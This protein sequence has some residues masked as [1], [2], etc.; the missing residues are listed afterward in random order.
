MT[1]RVVLVVDDE[2]DIRQIAT[3]ALGQVGGFEVRT[4]TSGAEAIDACLTSPPD[5]VLMDVMMPGLDGPA[6]LRRLREDPATATI[7]VVML[8]AKTRQ[9]D[10]DDLLRGGAQ[11][12]LAKPFD[13]LT[14]AGEFA[15][16]LGW[17]G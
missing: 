17:H 9:R 2:A 5:A 8:T 16:T 3:I 13:P 14:L 12:V 7:P 6:T 4:A 10:I 1:E 11:G 15:A